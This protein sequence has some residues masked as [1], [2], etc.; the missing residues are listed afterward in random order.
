MKNARLIEIFTAQ[1]REYQRRMR[2]VSQEMRDLRTLEYA[3]SIISDHT[4]RSNQ[5]LADAIGVLEEG[6]VDNLGLDHA[7]G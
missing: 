1:A 5:D 3:Q 6:I 7:R 4:G 2:L